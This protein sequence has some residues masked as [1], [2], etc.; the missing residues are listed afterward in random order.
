MGNSYLQYTHTYAHMV[1]MFLLP[2][3]EW[4]N[5]AELA[6]APLFLHPTDDEDVDIALK[7]AQVTIK[8][9]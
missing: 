4:D 1:V 5:D 7:L 6:V 9:T 8:A 3:Q 2:S